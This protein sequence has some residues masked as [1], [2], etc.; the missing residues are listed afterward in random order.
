MTLATQGKAWK[1]LSE[2]ERVKASERYEA[3]LNR[4]W[5]SLESIATK[6]SIQVENLLQLMKSQ[7]NPPLSSGL[8]KLLFPS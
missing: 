2:L 8:R 4:Y 1:E 6:S 7:I 3:K 5:R